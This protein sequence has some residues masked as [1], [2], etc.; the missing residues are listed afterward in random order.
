M[1]AVLSGRCR[2]VKFG[3]RSECL[4]TCEWS[5]RET[6]CTMYRGLGKLG[7]GFSGSPS[8]RSYKKAGR[9]VQQPR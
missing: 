4:M 9:Q 3:R 1:S 6:A 5:A 7:D 8:L 2:V